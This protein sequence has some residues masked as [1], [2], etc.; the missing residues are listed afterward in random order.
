MRLGILRGG[1]RYQERFYL[2]G[3][4]A[5]AWCWGGGFEGPPRVRGRRSLASPRV[6][7]FARVEGTVRRR[8]E[9]QIVTDQPDGREELSERRSEAP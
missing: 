8:A 2:L 4:V 9:R 6:P 3:Y 5:A 1:V 7:V